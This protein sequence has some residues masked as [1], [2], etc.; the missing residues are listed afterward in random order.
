MQLIAEPTNIVL[1]IVHRCNLLLI[2]L[3]RIA[4]SCN[5]ESWNTDIPI[6]YLSL[7]YIVDSAA[8][9]VLCFIL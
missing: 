6:H 5:L 4:Q 9:H 8:H 1:G 2:T 7:S 3:Q